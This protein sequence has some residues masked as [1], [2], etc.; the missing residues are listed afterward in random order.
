MYTNNEKIQKHKKLLIE[1]YDNKLIE[2]YIVF[3][4]MSKTNYLY[5]EKGL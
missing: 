4:D 2:I 3:I 5:V 1:I